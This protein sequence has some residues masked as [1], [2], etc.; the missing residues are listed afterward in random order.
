MFLLLTYLL[1]SDL[2][3]S[4]PGYP[5]R[6]KQLLVETV[7]KKTGESK[8]FLIETDSRADNGDA[9]VDYDD[10]SGSKWTQGNKMDLD[11]P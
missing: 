7:D 8:H 10:P 1:R 4:S 3:T 9:N 6:S 11:G 5:T 2:G